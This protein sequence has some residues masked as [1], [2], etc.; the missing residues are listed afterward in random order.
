M[1]K[2]IFGYYFD[3]H[4]DSFFENLKTELSHYPD[5][6]TA[7]EGAERIL[8]KI[9]ERETDSDFISSNPSS[10]K[11]TENGFVIDLEYAA[12]F[13]DLSEL[14]NNSII[15]HLIPRNVRKGL[16]GAISRF[17]SIGYEIFPEDIGKILHE[18]IFVPATFFFKDKII[19]HGASLYNRA[20]KQSIVLGGTGGVG[21][22]SALVK[23][24]Q[25]KEWVFLSD[26]IV[27][28]D[29]RGT[30]YPNY[31]YPKIYAYNTINNKPLERLIL[32]QDGPLGK[33]QWRT[34]AKY[35]RSRV[36]RRISPNL[37]Y[38]TDYIEP[39][40]NHNL[41]LFRCHRPESGGL[42]EIDINASTVFE[43]QIILA[44]YDSFLRFLRWYEYN[45][46][47]MGMQPFAT[48][49]EF[50]KNYETVSKRIFSTSKNYLLKIGSELSFDEYT[51]TIC[52]EVERLISNGSQ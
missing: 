34:I 51:K 14:K 40:L 43:K 11:V 3:I 1:K 35:N 52:S 2:I 29:E 22:T 30:I 50:T 4:L 20:T 18:L 28:I 26:D 31:S 44:E 36:R 49:D 48:L 9:D 21:K 5:H 25:K 8:I 45:A 16:R 12:I 38:S 19:L 37:L 32:S 42:E 39:A 7:P 23:L 6:E 27:V 41:F 17:R 10:L 13:W 47:A 33:F 15:V 24:G 46:I